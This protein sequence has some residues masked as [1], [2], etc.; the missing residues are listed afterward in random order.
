MYVIKNSLTQRFKLAKLSVTHN[1]ISILLIAIFIG[2]LGGYG[3]VFFR[4]VIKL[5]QYLFYLNSIDIL[6][7]AQDTPF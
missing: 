2:I 4:F 6:T 7:I 1:Q 5:M 3:A